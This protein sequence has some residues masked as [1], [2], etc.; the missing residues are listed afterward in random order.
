MS[1]WISYVSQN[2]QWLLPYIAL[3]IWSLYGDNGVFCGAGIESL[4]I[5]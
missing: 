2:K 4:N 3:T 5:I 1:L